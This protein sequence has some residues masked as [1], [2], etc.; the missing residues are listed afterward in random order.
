MLFIS[1]L[2]FFFGGTFCLSKCE[3]SLH[4][5]LPIFNNVNYEYLKKFNKFYIAGTPQSIGIF[6]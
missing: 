4:Y 2:D 5:K 3:I 6:K 1:F